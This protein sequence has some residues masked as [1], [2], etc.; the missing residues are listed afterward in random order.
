MRGRRRA[1]PAEQSR[2]RSLTFDVHRLAMRSVGLDRPAPFTAA[3]NN[4]TPPG[5]IHVAGDFGPWQKDDPG[6]TPLAATYE[7]NNA[8]LGHFKGISGILSSTGKFG[9]VL[10]RILVDGETHTPDFSV[11]AGGHPMPLDTVFHAIVD[12]TS[13]DTLL[14]PVRARLAN[15]TTIIANGGVVKTPG[16]KGRTV[17]LDVTVPEGRL[18][19]VLRLA[20]KSDKPPMTGGVTFRTKFDLPPGEGSSRAAPPA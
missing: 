7:F 4:P 19:D 10:E 3:L 6:Q 12:G 17:A 14:Q 18:Q 5:E 11:D 20:V 1:A 16:K 9:G 13:G 2:Q 8:D 15:S